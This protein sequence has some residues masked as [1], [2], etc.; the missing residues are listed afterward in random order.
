MLRFYIQNLED[1]AKFW[2]DVYTQNEDRFSQDILRKL[3]VLCYAPNSMWGYILS[4]YYMR[5]E[6]ASRM[7][8]LKKFHQYINVLNLVIR[9]REY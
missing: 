5:W 4:V 1:L 9:H 2:E 3:Y 6:T 7:D 8:F